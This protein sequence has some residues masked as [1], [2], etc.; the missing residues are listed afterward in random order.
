MHEVLWDFEI[1]IDHQI[2]YRRRDQVIV[3]KRPKKRT[4]CIVEFAIPAD[5]RVKIKE[6]EKR[7]KYL[8]LARKLKKLWNR[9]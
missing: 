5:H 8:N 2:L 7:D 4:C 6:S 9:T 3:N 1:Q